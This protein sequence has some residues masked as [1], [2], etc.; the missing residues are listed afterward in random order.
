MDSRYK[1]LL[2][3]KEDEPRLS[4]ET[5]TTLDALDALGDHEK[6]SDNGVVLPTRPPTLFGSASGRWI[7]LL[8][9]ILLVTSLT[10]FALALNVRSSTLRFVREFSAWCKSSPIALLVR[11]SSPRRTAPADVSVQYRS[12]KY[13]VSTK[14]N[15]FVGAGPDI[16]KAWRSI[17]YD[18]TFFL[19]SIVAVEL[20][21]HTVGD[22]WISKSD[23]AQLGMPETS[24]KVNHPQTGEEG[25]RVGI[26]VLQ[27]D[28][29]IAASF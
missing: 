12:M 15:P 2:T 16:D 17:S 19:L 4:Y 6:G 20:I 5:S 29:R 26:E 24:V 23:L 8:H 28:R 11:R 3:L 9:A 1:L 27:L 14:D 21:L 25:Y 18:G 7:W 10:L 13:N 22:Q